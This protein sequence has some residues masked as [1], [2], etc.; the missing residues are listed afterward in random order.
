MRCMAFMQEDAAAAQQQRQHGESKSDGGGR[1]N[2][3]GE[4]GDSDKN[5]QAQTIGKMLSRA[6]E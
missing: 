4:R 3:R 2:G 1:E 5:S 6:G